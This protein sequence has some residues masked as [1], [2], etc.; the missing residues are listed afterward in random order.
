MRSELP[1]DGSDGHVTFREEEHNLSMST[2]TKEKKNKKR[3]K[4]Q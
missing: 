3:I 2:C 4:R 1:G